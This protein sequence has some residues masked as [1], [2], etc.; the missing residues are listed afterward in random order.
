[1]SKGTIDVCDYCCKWVSDH[2]ERSPLS[3]VED[4]PKMMRRVLME[5][6]GMSR[7]AAN[8]FI[9]G[10]CEGNWERMHETSVERKVDAKEYSKM[11]LGDVFYCSDRWGWDRVIRIQWLYKR[12]EWRLRDCEVD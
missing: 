8:S 5:K 9:R 2:D 3:V 4:Y 7:R 1:M 10:A 6:F 12:L 11:L